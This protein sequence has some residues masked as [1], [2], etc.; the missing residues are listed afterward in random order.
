MEREVAVAAVWQRGIE[1]RFD[2]SFVGAV[3]CHIGLLVL[4]VG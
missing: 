3:A 2:G 4:R 1:A